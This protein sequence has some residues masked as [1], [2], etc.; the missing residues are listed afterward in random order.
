M[1][2]D[3]TESEL[4]AALDAL[5]DHRHKW[6]ETGLTLNHMRVALIAAAKVRGGTQPC[7][8]PLSLKIS[9]VESDHTFCELCESQNMQRDAETAEAANLA[10]AERAERERDKA[11]AQAEAYKAARNAS[12]D[13][14]ARLREAL[15]KARGMIEYAGDTA[16]IAKID[17]ALVGSGPTPSGNF[18]HLKDATM[19]QIRVAREIAVRYTDEWL[20]LRND[21]L[22]A[23]LAGS[24]P[25]PSR[26][27]VTPPGEPVG[28]ADTD[29]PFDEDD[30]APGPATHCE[31]ADGG[32][33]MTA[34]SRG[35]A[36]R[37]APALSTEEWQPIETAPKDETLFL[38]ATSDGR[39][40]IW[41]GDILALT[42][43]VEAERARIVA[44][45]RRDAKECG[46]A[47]YTVLMQAANDEWK[48][49]ANSK[50]ASERWVDLY[51]YR[52][53]RGANVAPI[54]MPRWASR[55]TLTVTDVRVQRLQEISEA[56]AEVEGVE[57]AVFPDWPVTTFRGAY[58]GL[59]ESLHGPGAWAENP[60][61]AAITFTIECRNIDAVLDDAP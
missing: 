34:S 50:E 20:A 60:W 28:R 26:D 6:R 14:A 39:V 41:R 56:D 61:V 49:I 42:A 10:R 11:R 38:T 27:Y 21:I 44:R 22:E 4:R 7:G 35:D 19:E 57:L 12:S 13:Y 30:D 45:L 52:G 1:P 33:P 3:P 37:S 58:R 29:H 8:H 5:M 32:G 25:S 23:M 53:K 51:G 18:K 43:A 46:P 17:A 59:W 16:L 47:G 2:T 48:P 24:A 31:R 55:L 54:H 15:T 40:M 36:A 9:S